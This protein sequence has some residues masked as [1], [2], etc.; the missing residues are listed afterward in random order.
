[1]LYISGINAMYVVIEPFSS[2]CVL[3]ACQIPCLYHN[4]ANQFENKQYTSNPTDSEHTRIMYGIK[5]MLVV[6]STNCYTCDILL[7]Y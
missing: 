4:V 1:M 7:H 3:H 5:C 6:S 2:K